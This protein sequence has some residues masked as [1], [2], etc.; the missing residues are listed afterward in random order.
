MLNH[1]WACMMLIGICYGAVNGSMAE[2]GNGLFASA[3]EA[4][5]LCISM[6]GTV[7]FWNGLMEIALKAGLIE[8][9][10]KALN[11]ILRW[12]FPRLDASSEASGYIATNIIA[13]V[14][15][16]GWACTPSGLK[17]MEALAEVEQKR[18]GV[19]TVSDASEEMC[20]FLILNVS[21]LQLIPVNMIAYRTQYGS[22]NP[23]AILLPAILATTV[24]TL[25][26]I[27]FAKFSAFYCSK[28]TN[29]LKTRFR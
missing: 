21:S 13:N 7:A 16:L 24:S 12:L 19:H 22:V 17:A 3:K 6:A 20:T 27:L 23:S 10:K 28:S 4:I 14:L 1:I 11:P 2:V 9:W 26:A 8:Q 5:L 29:F 25:A 18:L 15:G